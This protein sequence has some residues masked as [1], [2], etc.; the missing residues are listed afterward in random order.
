MVRSQL[1]TGSEAG[2]SRPTS[3]QRVPSRNPA[4]YGISNRA[5]V[6]KCV[7]KPAWMVPK[8]CGVTRE[9]VP[10]RAAAPSPQEST[11]R[12][13]PLTPVH[14]PRARP[15]E[16][17]ARIGEGGMGEVYRAR[18]TETSGATWRSKI[19]PDAPPSLANLLRARRPLLSARLR[20]SIEPNPSERSP[21]STGLNLGG[22]P[23]FREAFA[24]NLS[25]PALAS[26]R[27]MLLV[28]TNTLALAAQAVSA[29]R[30]LP[31][32][33]SDHCRRPSRNPCEADYRRRSRQPLLQ[34]HR[35]L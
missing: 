22:M 11:P 6:A 30:A 14:P 25:R 26:A 1:N 20:R 8:R 29:P 4:T 24:R 18:D 12:L 34:A 3:S 28:A 32:R 15:H 33:G 27:R 21:A 9:V 31:S 35:G 17:T 5:G 16:V 23:C 19:L 7:P 13:W 2:P 10:F